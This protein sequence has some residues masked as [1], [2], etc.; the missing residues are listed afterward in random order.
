MTIQWMEKRLAFVEGLFANEKG[1]NSA[2]D[3]MANK[4]NDADIARLTFMN[5]T[6]S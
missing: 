1:K 3:E 5:Q 4:I 2:L 6:E